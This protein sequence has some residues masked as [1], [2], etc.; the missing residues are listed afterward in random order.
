[1]SV[2]D[3]ID[4]LSDA[5]SDIAAAIESKG[6]T[7]PE[8]T[9]LDG[10]A[11]LINAI[12][13]GAV[14][15]VNGY[16]GDVTG[17]QAVEGAAIV[18]LSVNTPNSGAQ[19]YETSDKRGVF[20]AN[21]A[22]GNIG[23]QMY[24][25]TGGGGALVRNASS[26]NVVTLA[27]GVTTFQTNAG[28]VLVGNASGNNRAILGVDT[29]GDGVLRLINSDGDYA[30]LSADKIAILNNIYPVG[31]IYMSVNSTSPATY[32]GGTWARIQD[33]FLLAAGSSY[34]AGAT[35]GEATHTLTVDEMP[36]HRHSESQCKSVSNQINGGSYSSG[37]PTSGYT[38]YAG[39]GKAH[40]NMPPYLA[41]YVWKRTA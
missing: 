23:A 20:V 12:E 6:V 2:Q 38:G 1:M 41:V 5:K 8:T 18:P 33:T 32:F 26:K 36:S 17:A 34:A 10:M 29:S 31:S 19:M 7:V 11:T 3:Q 14:T 16:T 40:N 25:G 39:G 37:D 24:G 4:R 13:T 15:S 28:G 35:G 30:T 22:S 27:S 9:A 21:D